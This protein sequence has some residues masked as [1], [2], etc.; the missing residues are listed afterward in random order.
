MKREIKFYSENAEYGE[1]SNFYPSPIKIGKYTWA[2]V[3]HYFQ[4]QKFKGAEYEHQIRK[5][6]SPMKAAELGRT[7]KVKMR[8]HWE[9]VK[10]NIMREALMAKF[11]Q[12]PDLK[13]I[14]L[15]TEEAILIEHTSNDSY[16]GD[17]GDGSG[18]NMLGKLLME[19]RDRLKT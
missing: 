10:V 4:A 3:E 7:R 15:Q 8:K 9:S 1:L 18:K 11:T 12:H 14:L 16:W 5:A 6:P 17:R 19:I 13:M 2:T